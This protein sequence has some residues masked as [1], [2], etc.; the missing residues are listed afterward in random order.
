MKTITH[1]R[2]SASIHSLIPVL[3]LALVSATF[4][5]DA[6]AVPPT[7]PIT[8]G[9]R[10]F[11]CGHSFHASVVP[12]LIAE[13]A[14]S[15]EIKDHVVAGV[16]MIGGSRA[17]QHFAV[18]DE[19]NKAKALLKEGKIDVLTL[20]CM[21]TPDDGIGSFAKLAVEHNPNV[22]VTLQ[23]LWL[24]DDHWPF[25]PAHRIHKSPEDFN[26]TTM[27]E[28]KKQNEAYCKAMEDTV[29]AVNA[30]VGKVAVFLVPDVLAT[31]A[32][33]EKI[34]AGTAPGLQKQSDLFGDG[35]GHPKAPLALL[36][37]YCHYSV[38]Y[39]RSPVGLPIPPSSAKAGIKDEALNKL[40]QELAWGAVSH[41]PMSGVKDEGKK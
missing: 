12:N 16:S 40:L 4:A 26:S 10:V 39:R 32:L 9:L 18:P 28:L 14:K 24:P 2:S 38:I 27:D 7:G 17:N 21:S 37:A 34:I 23:E 15:A 36:S 41:Y 29:K 25:D 22:R 8:A 6:P 31:L 3:A 13:I 19:K 33:R 11:T 30:S 5:A 1:P 20:S 35:W